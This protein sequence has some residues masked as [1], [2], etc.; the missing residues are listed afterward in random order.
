MVIFAVRLA[1]AE[2][3]AT[4]L[5][6]LVQEAL[7]INPALSAARSSAEASDR[8]PPQLG[9]LP[10]PVLAL[11]L[12]NFRVDDPSLSASPMSG[13]QLALRQNLPFPG[14]LGRRRDIARAAASVAWSRVALNEAT[15][16]ARVKAAYWD[17]YFA[18]VAEDLTRNNTEILNSLVD[19]A[20]ARFAVGEAI[21]QDVL[22]AQVAYAQ[23]RDALFTRE[24]E[25]GTARERLNTSIGRDPSAPLSSPTTLPGD[26][27]DLD[28]DTIVQEALENSP[29]LAVERNLVERSQRV[30]REA[31]Y[32]RWPDLTLASGYRVRSDVIGDRTAGADMFFVS[33]GFNLPIFAH[34]KQNKHVEESLERRSESEQNLADAKLQIQFDAQRL[35]DEIE[36][37]TR[38]E[39][40]YRTEILKE[41]QMALDASLADYQVAR[42][43]F[44]SVLDNW[45]K[46]FDS[47]LA[48]ERI[49]ADREARL[50]T[51]EAVVGRPLP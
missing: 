18:A 50:A 27:Y 21:Q 32:D 37:L 51:L 29:R 26:S 46:L 30:V 15:V 8:V 14:K 4:Y 3:P 48:Y 20:N 42:V 22:K 5:D 6:S 39:K 10:D 1:I 24:Q 43:E 33:V 9:S 23:L 44:I 31:R 36:R 11:D 13:I 41:A 19:I 2:P 16:T 49:R 38:Q 17:Y 34:T 47:E 28:R 12:S 7:S 25:T 40:I 45:R 35:I